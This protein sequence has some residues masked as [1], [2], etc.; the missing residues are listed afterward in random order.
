VRRSGLALPCGWHTSS[1]GTA[2]KRFRQLPS[3]K[4]FKPNSNRYAITVGLILVLGAMPKIATILL[5]ILLSGCMADRQFPISGNL[6]SSKGSPPRECWLAFESGG[7]MHA[8]ALPRPAFDEGYA[9]SSIPKTVALICSGYNPVIKTVP[10]DGA[11]GTVVLEA[12]DGA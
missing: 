12:R 2:A 1:Q 6:V 4:S 10:T 11:L 7:Q 9:V 3:N 8:Y 5:V